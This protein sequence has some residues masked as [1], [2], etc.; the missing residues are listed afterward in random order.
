MSECPNYIDES[1]EKVE[2]GLTLGLRRTPRNAPL[3]K[4]LSRREKLGVSYGVRVP[5]G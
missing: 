2:R 5:V 1:V 4:T 3:T